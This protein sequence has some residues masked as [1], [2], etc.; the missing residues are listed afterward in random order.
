MVWFNQAHA[1]HAASLDP[2]VREALLA[3]KTEEEFPRN[4]C[5]GDGT[6]IDDSVI[7]EIRQAY[8][9]AAVTFDWQSGDILMIEN[10]LVAHGRAPFTGARRILVAMSGAINGNDVEA[11][12]KYD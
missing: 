8:K 4:A 3:E 2:S 1:F 12:G 5:Y 11:T 6:R 7:E 9:T 10:M